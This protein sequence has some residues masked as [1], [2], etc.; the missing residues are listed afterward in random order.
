ML[1]RG[2]L[3]SAW[4]ISSRQVAPVSWGRRHTPPAVLGIPL[5]A[6][7]A[8]AGCQAHPSTADSTP[9][10]TLVFAED[11]NGQ[12]SSPPADSRWTYDVGGTGWGNNEL[13]YYTDNVANAALDG[14][15]HLVISALR[16][17][18]SGLTC[19][20]GPCDYTSAR[21]TTDQ[22][23]SQ[24]YGHFEARIK[25]PRGRGIWPAFWLLSDGGDDQP[26][27]YGEIDVMELLGHDP[28]TI[29]GSLHGSDY[30]TS[31]NYS[32]PRSGPF[33]D[34]FHVF[35]ID[36]APNSV[37]FSVDGHVYEIQQRVTAGDRW[38]FDHRFYILLN[39]AVGG[40]WPGSPDDT[41]E[42]PARMV[43]DYVRVYSSPAS[44][45]SGR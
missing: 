34:D 1:L 37:S 4:P 18:N 9:R 16:D 32:L 19:W 23:F 29:H 39:V 6:L 25:L 3:W 36:W 35:A 27:R 26:P 13:E 12:V 42:F 2:F 17:N 15:G 14:S 20:Y 24:A 45:T 40:D 10:P 8:A 22:K 31:G 7:L 11:F 43:V 41:T 5:V 28:G 33:S 30:H 44:P 38:V 21:L